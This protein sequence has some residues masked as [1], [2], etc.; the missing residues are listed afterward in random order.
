MQKAVVAHL[1]NSMAPLNVYGSAIIHALTLK[2]LIDAL[3][4]EQTHCRRHRLQR[5]KILGRISG[6][7]T[8]WLAAVSALV[9]VAASV[10]TCACHA[11]ATYLIRASATLRKLLAVE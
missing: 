3:A 10:D 11:A 2:R 7:S 9:A 6:V 4:A 8:A 1:P 5:V